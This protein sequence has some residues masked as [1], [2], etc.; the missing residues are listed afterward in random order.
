[1]ECFPDKLP[2][3]I[4]AISTQL[5]DVPNNFIQEIKATSDVS[6]A[7]KLLLNF[8]ILQLNTGQ[9]VVDLCDTLE[10]LVTGSDA[11]EVVEALRNGT[12]QL[13]CNVKLLF[14]YWQIALHAEPC[15]YGIFVPFRCISGSA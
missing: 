3:I 1:V 4:E 14:Y 12:S 8:L 5:P 7:N 11:V 13:N 9:D 15:C 2:A 10:A 6:T